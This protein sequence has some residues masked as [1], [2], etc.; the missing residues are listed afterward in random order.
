MTMQLRQSGKAST[1]ITVVVG[2]FFLLAFYG[3]VNDSPSSGT[4]RPI[5]SGLSVE[6]VNIIEEA[7]TGLIAEGLVHSM[8]VASNTVRIEPLIWTAWSLEDKQQLVLSL[9]AYFEAKGSTGRVKILS[10]CNDRQ[11][12]TYSVWSGVKIL[13]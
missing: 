9:S 7:M 11:L 13:L 4:G 10:N 3:W 5:R 8:D 12:A 1:I 2:G 6:A